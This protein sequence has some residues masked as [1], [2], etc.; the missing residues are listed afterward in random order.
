MANVRVRRRAYT[1]EIGHAQAARQE[2]LYSVTVYY[3]CSFYSVT[4]YYFRRHSVTVF[5]F[6]SSPGPGEIL[7]SF[8]SL[9]SFR[10][11]MEAAAPRHECAELVIS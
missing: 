2:R 6:L 8:M 4:V 10:E 1:L 5:L 11:M 9:T 7:T 3:S